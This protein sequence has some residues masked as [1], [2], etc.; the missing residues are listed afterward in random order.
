M[1][2]N[3]ERVK[4]YWKISGISFIVKMVDDPGMEGEVKK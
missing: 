3:D 4:E 2:E 1:A